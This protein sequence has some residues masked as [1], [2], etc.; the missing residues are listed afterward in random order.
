MNVQRSLRE[1]PDVV[2]DFICAL[3][4]LE[5]LRILVVRG[6]IL[7]NCA[8]QLVDA[9]ENAATDG[10]FGKQCKPSLDQIEP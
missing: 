3:R 2:K 6:K 4:P 8:L 9:F 5:R 7:A 1:A 10:L